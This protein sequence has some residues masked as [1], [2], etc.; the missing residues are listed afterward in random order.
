MMSLHDLIFDE[1]HNQTLLLGPPHS[2]RS[3]LAMRLAYE[4]ALR[5]GNPLF[6]CSKMKIE[7]SPPIFTSYSISENRGNN[8]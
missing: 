7:S 2:G 8:I 3:S 6:I 4:E 1:N 5:G